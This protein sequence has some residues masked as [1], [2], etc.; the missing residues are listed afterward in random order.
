MR[1]K[2]IQNLQPTVAMLLGTAFAFL[3]YFLLSLVFS[4]I[5]LATPDPLCFIGIASMA[6]LF[7]SGIVSSLVISKV[8]GEGGFLTAIL[9]ALLFCLIQLLIGLI[10][11]KGDIGLGAIINYLCYMAISALAALIGKGRKRKIKY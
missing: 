11:A 7:G 10:V 4:A 5:T 1:R 9:S 3:C 8:R 6:A 2:G